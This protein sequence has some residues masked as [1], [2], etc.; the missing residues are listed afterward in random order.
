MGPRRHKRSWREGPVL[1]IWRASA[2]GVAPR[3]RASAEHGCRCRHAHGDLVSA[4]L[5]T[6]CIQ[7]QTFKGRSVG[8]VDAVCGTA[9]CDHRCVARCVCIGGQ[10]ALHEELMH[11]IVRRDARTRE[12]GHRERV[13]R[14]IVGKQ[15]KSA[16]AVTRALVAVKWLQDVPHRDRVEQLGLRLG[17]FKVGVEIHVFELTD[18]SGGQQTR[19]LFPEARH[20]TLL[21]RGRARGWARRWRWWRARGRRWW[22]RRWRGWWRARWRTWWRRRGWAWRR[23]GRR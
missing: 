8:N 1:A 23:A 19:M 18:I 17:H 11:V 14:W 9:R 7:V 15:R 21:R 5:A 12:G 10:R 6:P 16:V 2:D 4:R 3:C 22:R 13:C 20:T